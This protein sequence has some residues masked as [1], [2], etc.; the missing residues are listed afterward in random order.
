MRVAPK[1]LRDFEGIIVGSRY[2]L[3]RFLDEGGFGAVFRAAHIAYGIE[4]RDVAIKIAKRP[5]EEAEARR[6]F[7]DALTMARLADTAPNVSIRERF[8]TVFDAGYC[9]KEGPL[10]GHPY[11]V[12]ELVKGGSLRNFLQLGPFPLTRA[13]AYFDQILEGMSFMHDSSPYGATERKP[14]IHRDL[15]PANI[16]VIRRSNEVDVLKI[17][18]FGLAV[19][20]D[21]LLGWVESGG[22]LGYLAP[23]SFTHNISSPQSDVFTLGLLFYEMISGNNPFGEVGRHLRGTDDEKRDELRKLHLIA[24]QLEQF[25]ILDSHEELRKSPALAK[26]IR[27]SLKPDMS[28]REYANAGELR[29]A[30]D[31]AKEEGL[32]GGTQELPWEIVRSLINQAEQCIRV[33]AI[34]QGE[35]K[36]EEAFELNRDRQRIPDAMSVGR[37]YLLMVESLL[38]KGKPEAAGRL[39]YE[40]Y[41]R[42]KGHSTCLAV[43]KFLEFK[44]SPIAAHFHRESVEYPGTD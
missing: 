30:W 4:L 29:S 1:N 5:M 18:D 9:L 13:I 24:R 31:R 6:V 38:S 39:A 28:S 25:P 7:G 32:P 43:A 35:A 14:L 3:D 36:L 22:D 34:D 27:T 26:V 17:S 44:K 37:C 16:L 15:K 10:A 23:E 2:R 40:G 19:E 21:S 12:M 8:V 33:G 41:N 20:V 11:M 42:N